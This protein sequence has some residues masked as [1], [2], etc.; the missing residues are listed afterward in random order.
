MIPVKS[1]LHVPLGHSPQ[2]GHNEPTE[3]PVFCLHRFQCSSC[4]QNWASSQVQV[5][6][7]M[8]WSEG[9]SRGQVKMRIFSQRC[10]KCSQSSFEVPKFTEENI[11]RILNN[12]VLRILKKCYGEGFK[13]VEIPIIKEVSLEGP[14]D[15]DNCEA[16]LQGFCIQSGLGLA[17][18]APMSPSL[19]TISSP[20]VEIAIQ[21]PSPTRS[22]TTEDAVKKKKVIPRPWFPEATQAESLPTSWSP[23]A[24]TNSQNQRADISSQSPRADTNSSQSQRVDISSQNLRAKTNSQSP[25]RKTNSQSPRA[26]TKS[27]SPRTDTSSQRWR[28][29]TYLQVERRVQ[30]SLSRE[31]YYSHTAQTFRSRNLGCCCCLILIIIVIVIVIKIT[32]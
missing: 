8:H 9:E 14:H 32:I 17:T 20:P 31:V 4:S 1:C 10:K 28:A 11:S 2:L 26:K 21:M 24:D 7:H 23:R 25:R 22:S 3:G 30:D 16:C 5:L 15:S 19:P 13:L 27:Q 12:L 29:N 18:Q 6:F